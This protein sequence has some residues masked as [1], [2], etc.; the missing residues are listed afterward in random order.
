MNFQQQPIQVKNISN[1]PVAELKRN[2]DTRSMII[3]QIKKHYFVQYH[4]LI[5]TKSVDIIFKRQRKVNKGKP[6]KVE[7]GAP[8]TH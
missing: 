2:T 5:M 3:R 8:G 7:A 4:H 1:Y 6:I